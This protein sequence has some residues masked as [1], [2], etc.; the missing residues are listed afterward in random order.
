MSQAPQSCSEVAVDVLSYKKIFDPKLM[1]LRVDTY[2][3]GFV[4]GDDKIEQLVDDLLEYEKKAG[5]D[6]FTLNLNSANTTV[7]A[8]KVSKHS[9]VKTPAMDDKKLSFTKAAENILSTHGKKEPMH[10]RV[11]TQK[12]LELGLLNTEGQTPEATMYRRFSRRSAATR[13]GESNHASSS[14]RA[15]LLA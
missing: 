6:C 9:K 11:I 14:T 1:A 10:Y 7:S 5:P 2:Q 3:S 12:A 15:A 8:P 13:C 4:W